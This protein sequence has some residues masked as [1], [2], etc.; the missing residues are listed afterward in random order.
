MNAV[1]GEKL[2]STKNDSAIATLNAGVYGLHMA[3]FAQ[4]LLRLALFFSGLL[5]C[6]MIASGLLLWSLKRQLQ[7]KTEK[8]HFGYY[9]VQ[10]LN[11]TAIIGLPIAVLSYF[12]SNRIGLMLQS[13]QNYE[14]TTFFAVWL[15]IFAISLCIKKQYLWK[16]QLA[17][18]IALAFG[19]AIFNLF[20]LLQQNHIQNQIQNFAQFW[21]FFRI[22]LFM[23]IFGLLAIFLYKNIQPIQLKAQTKITNKLERNVQANYGESRS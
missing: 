8:F 15:F 21:S 18:F 22:D 12:Y 23:L 14:V 16:K 11:V 5:G 20:F 6:A 19:L 10:R 17:I 9:L 13:T 2:H 3:T 4:P 7:T 1:T